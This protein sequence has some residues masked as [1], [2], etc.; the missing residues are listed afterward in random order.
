MVM[1]I[2]I[3]KKK[4]QET[5]DSDEEHAHNLSDLENSINSDTSTEH[6]DDHGHDHK[7][8]GH[9]HKEHDHDHKDK[10]DKKKKHDHDYHDSH[11]KGCFSSFD[12]NTFA[13][14]IHYAG[15]ALSSLFI[16]AAGFILKYEGTHQWTEYVDPVSSLLIVLLILI[17]TL[18]L[19]K[20]CGTILLQ[21]APKDFDH[22]SLKKEISEVD[23]IVSTHDNHIWQLVD[24]MLISSIHVIVVEGT[25]FNKI[26]KKLKK[27][28]HRHGIHSSST[29]PEFV[30]KEAYAVNEACVQNCVP[31]CEEDWCC[32]KTAEV[33]K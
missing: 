9:D 20:R 28:L 10:K 19:V 24:G 6:E 23:G 18:P 17:T 21:S 29:Q 14:L 26:A 11:N 30:P 27:I 13:I 5:S 32:K 33:D 2:K 4:K 31:E 22:K 8:H 1:I 25:D 3:R 7:E 16:L 12:L 15:D